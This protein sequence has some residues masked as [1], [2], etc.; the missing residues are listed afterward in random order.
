MEG[1]RYFEEIASRLDNEEMDDRNP[2]RAIRSWRLNLYD[3][4]GAGANVTN[5]RRNR[6]AVV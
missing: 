4:E 1:L 6:F 3:L 5:P 2:V